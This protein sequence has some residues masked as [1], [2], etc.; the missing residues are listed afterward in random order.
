MA[1]TQAAK[2]AAAKTREWLVVIPDHA[3]VL[4][5]RIAIRPQ[6]SPNFVNLHQE[7][8]VSWAGPLFTK[9]IE[10][11]KTRPFKGSAMVL[12]DRDKNGI[13]KRL[14]EDVYVKENIWDLDNALIAPFRTL[15]RR[16]LS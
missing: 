4:A 15:R 9:H 11:S 2:S 6:H 8:Y 13:L 14:S 7:G 1:S 5:R 16:A 12:N 10:A 3:G